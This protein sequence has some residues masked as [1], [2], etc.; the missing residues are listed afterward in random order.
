[1]AT[2]DAFDHPDMMLRLR[3]QAKAELRK[4]ARQLRNAIPQSALSERSAQLVERLLGLPELQSKK[5][6]ALFYPIESR[7]EVDLLAFDAKVREGG[8]RVAYPSVKRETGEMSFQWVANLNELEEQ[9]NG[10]RE[11]PRDA[12][13]A[14]EIDVIVVPA[15]LVDERGYRLGY[16]AGYYDRTLPRFCPPALSIAVGFDFQLTGELPNTAG[17]VRVS[18]VVTDK[19]VLRV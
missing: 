11:P 16:G 15:L 7:N 3:V 12:P 14:L 2:S 8:A 1:M 18:M 4:K 5:S 9:G 10:F 6:F 19:R 13:E 17:D